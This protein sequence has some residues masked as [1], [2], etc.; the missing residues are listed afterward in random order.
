M[1]RHTLLYDPV[2]LADGNRI[3][4]FKLERG[5]LENDLEAHDIAERMKERL[6]SGYRLPEVVIMEGEPTDNPRLFGASQSVA[7]IRSMLAAIAQH[8]WA[9]ATVDVPSTIK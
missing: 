7:L 6:R 2:R 4:L 3:H 1:R 5:A 8:A 9:P